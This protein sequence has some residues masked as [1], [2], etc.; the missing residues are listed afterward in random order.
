MTSS[1]RKSFWTVLL[2]P[3]TAEVVGYLPIDYF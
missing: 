3:A 2:D 1:G